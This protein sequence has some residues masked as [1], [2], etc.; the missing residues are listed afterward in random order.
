MVKQ[1]FAEV[2]TMREMV[3]KHELAPKGDM[4]AELLPLAQTHYQ[5]R[6]ESL[7]QIDKTSNP[8]SWA[9]TNFVQISHLLQVLL[10]RVQFSPGLV[11][12]NSHL[13]DSSSMSAS[14]IQTRVSNLYQECEP[15]RTFSPVL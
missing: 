15:K 6:F 10:H 1:D 7:C 3:L 8:P 4:P 2:S 11:D 12:F 9:K 5:R 13:L 14:P